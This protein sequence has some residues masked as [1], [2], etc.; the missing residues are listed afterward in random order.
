MVTLNEMMMVVKTKCLF[1]HMRSVELCFLK[2]CLIFQK[3]LKDYFD[4]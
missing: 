1:D 4:T 3:V 2:R